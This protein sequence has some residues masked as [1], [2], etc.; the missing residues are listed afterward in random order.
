MH[1]IKQVILSYISL[2]ITARQ[3]PFIVTTAHKMKIE[4]P[5]MP[6]SVLCNYGTQALY[7]CKNYKIYLSMN[8]NSLTSS[9]P[10][11]IKKAIN[12]HP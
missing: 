8:I 12:F 10:L 1:T 4:K 7:Y 5:Y 3:V 6:G 11:K 9:L 2:E